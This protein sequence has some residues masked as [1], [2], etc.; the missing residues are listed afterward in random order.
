MLRVA[1]LILRVN[2]STFLLALAAFS[3]VAWLLDPLF[4]RMGLALLTADSL[5]GFWTTLYNSTIWRFIPV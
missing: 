4:H 1:D 5:Q 3:G 2:L